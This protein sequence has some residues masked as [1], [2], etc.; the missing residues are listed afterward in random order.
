M[1]ITSSKDDIRRC[2]INLTQ[3]IIINK[4]VE[5]PSIFFKRFNKNYMKVNSDT[6]HLLMSIN[7]NVVANI[8]NNC[9]KFEDLHELQANL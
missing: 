3:K 5:S 9:F 6:S 4:Y 1:N 7:K 2:N 8:D